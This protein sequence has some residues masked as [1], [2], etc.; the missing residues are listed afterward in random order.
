MILFKVEFL[1]LLSHIRAV[2]WVLLPWF[3]HIPGK[4][5]ILFLKPWSSFKTKIIEP[6]SFIFKPWTQNYV[7]FLDLVRQR[8]I[9][10]GISWAILPCAGN[11][12]NLRRTFNLVKTD[13]VILTSKK[14]LNVMWDFFD[15]RYPIHCLLKLKCNFLSIAIWNYELCQFLRRESNQKVEKW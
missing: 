13:E 10:Y 2:A 8:V 3:A 4:V 5:L 9:R 14:H 6:W 1:M 11:N 12:Q 15:E 7:F